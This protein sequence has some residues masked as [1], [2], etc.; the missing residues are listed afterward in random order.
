MRRVH[1]LF[2]RNG[3]DGVLIPKH[4]PRLYCAAS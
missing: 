3:F 1:Q 4:T 2:Q